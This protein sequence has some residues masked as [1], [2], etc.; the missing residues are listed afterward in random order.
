[1]LRLNQKFLAEFDK[2]LNQWK[3]GELS[4]PELKEKLIEHLELHD[5]I[6][7]Q[8]INKRFRAMAKLEDL[9]KSVK[10]KN[11]EFKRLKSKLKEINQALI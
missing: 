2:M 5:R 1:M 7:R 3:T 9:Q 8:E 11:A 6:F 4:E 10:G